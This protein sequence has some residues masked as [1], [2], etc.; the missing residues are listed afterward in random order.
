VILLSFFFLVCV[1]TGVC[2]ESW[3]QIKG[4][5]FIVYFISN[6][7]IAKNTL[8]KAE[9]YYQKIANELGYARYS[10]FWQW[11]RRV[12]IYIYPDRSTYEN[13]LK[14]HNYAKWSVGMANYNNKEII[15]YAQSEE[16]L[17]A[18]LPHEITHLIFRDYVGQRNIPIWID[19]GV[20]QWEEKGKRRFVKTKIKQ[21]LQIHK[22]IPIERMMTLN[23]GG[24]EN[25]AIV[26]LYYVEAIS[27]IDFLITQ[28][29]IDNF[30]FFCRHLRDGKDINEALQFAYPT[31]IRNITTL[32]EKWLEYVQQEE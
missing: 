5:H 10:N 26:E 9:Q 18:T 30:I 17:D 2:A 29:G 21:L 6:E 22:P 25:P 13:Y 11:E 7:K 3:K 20:A 27:L 32:E 31:S 24:V 19:E 15:G 23:I 12:K 28:Y 16:F 4:E 8:S 14:K 1:A